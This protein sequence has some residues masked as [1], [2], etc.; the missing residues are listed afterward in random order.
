MTDKVCVL[1]T[2]TVI[3]FQTDGLLH[4][5]RLYLRR[6]RLPAYFPDSTIEDIAGMSSLRGVILFVF[7]I[8]IISPLSCFITHVIWLFPAN[9]IW[10]PMLYSWYLIFKKRI[11]NH[12]WRIC[13][14]YKTGQMSIA[15]DAGMFDKKLHDGLLHNN[16]LYLRRDRL[17]DTAGKGSRMSLRKNTSPAIC[18]EQWEANCH[19][20]LVIALF[21]H[22]FQILQL[23][24]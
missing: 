7:A 9:P 18:H 10:N 24:I 2:L 3:S 23:R 11:Y 16:R 19:M 13:M 21:L 14:L 1:L 6:D 12:W 20:P 17:P 5:N 22:I 15:S 8:I 4:N